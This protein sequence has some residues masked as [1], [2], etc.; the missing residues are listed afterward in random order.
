MK[1]AF[2]TGIVLFVAAAARGASTV[3]PWVPV[4]QGI[5]QATGTNDGTIS[6][7]SAH[8]MRIDLRDPDV[9]LIT[10]R[11]V[12]NNY[13]PDQRETQLQTPREFQIEYGTQV[14]INSGFFFPAGYQS[15]SGTPSWLQG[16]AISQGRAV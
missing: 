11:A 12:T 14:A 2:L 16:L 1:L 5:D 10:T 6:T 9:R 3:S 13:I 8:A 4:F 15:P 7:L